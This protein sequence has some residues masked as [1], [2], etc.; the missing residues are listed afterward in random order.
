[1]VFVS[2]TPIR[3][4]FT[5]LETGSY[6]Y[7]GG[8][9]ASGT[10]TD[11][12]HFQGGSGQD[13]LDFSGLGSAITVTYTSQGSGTITDGTD[14][15]SFSSIENLILTD[16][17]DLVDASASW[18]GHNGDR[19]GEN[20]DGGAGQD[21]ITG[22][23]G[24]DTIHGGDGH[25]VIDGGYGDDSLSGGAGDDTILG[26]EG[27]DNILGG[28]GAD[29]ID[30]GLE[31][32]TIDGG[33]GGDNIDGGSGAD[34]I[35]GG[36]GNDTIFGSS[37]QDT[38]TGGDGD[39]NLDGDTDDDL[40]SGGAGNDRLR[41]G[42]G[43][44][45][46]DG[47]IGDDVLDGD[48]G[49]DSLIGGDGS[50]YFDVYYGEGNDTIVGGDGGS[51]VDTLDFKS[52][53]SGQ[54]I[55]VIS[56]SDGAGTYQ[57]T[58]AASVGEYSGIERLEGTS[59]DDTFD[60]SNDGSGLYINAAE[61]N[62][63]VTAGA[64]DDTINAGEGEDTVYGGDGDDVING[65]ADRDEI[66]GDAGNDTIYGDSGDDLLLGD[67]GDDYIEGGDGNDS[68]A[69]GEG[70]DTLWGGDGDDTLD[71]WFGDD[72]FVYTGDN[73]T[74]TNFNFDN[75]GTLDDG[76]STNNDYI[77]LSGFYDHISELY[78]DQADDGVL[79]QSNSTDTRGN[80]TDYSDNT[81]FNGGS[82][83]MQGASAD[84]SS[85]T[86]ENT[87][88][89]CFTIGTSIRTPRGDVLIEDLRIGDLVATADNGPQ[90]IRWIGNRTLDHETLTAAPNLRPILIH[91]AVLGNDRPLLVSPQHCM[92]LGSNKLVRAKHLAETMKD[93]QIAHGKRRVSYVHLMFDS[94]Q[95]IFAENAPSESFY[96]GPMSLQ[97]MGDC[98]RIELFELFPELRTGSNCR[99]HIVHEYGE[100]ARSILK[101]RE[102]PELLAL[103]IPDGCTP[104]LYPSQYL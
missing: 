52:N 54:G 88:I 90:A 71:G 76:D 94:H 66:Y 36:D 26:G 11:I 39:D 21:T 84:N 70:N 18:A 51:N 93:V 16:Q 67:D 44:D 15:I 22:G 82:L 34:L 37:G 83:R 98:S 47:G 33:H 57:T 25:D 43:N 73:D 89:V 9:G 27:N 91:R 19:V 86:E 74:I 3:L 101:K 79:N 46:L 96:P 59:E 24:G 95:V 5:T 58:D 97:M 1:M 64:G 40:V 92:L 78:A 72:V 62:D 55:D 104:R 65:G 69:G 29:S 48:S 77:D 42:S 68:I 23:R 28:D 4:T 99:E 8:G 14:T 32:D 13:T 38:I 81:Q 49:D 17:D 102:L 12:E 6:A 60:T 20:I 31:A 45:T 63:D 30:G 10:F 75:L 35:E 56:T 2:A 50:D 61:G 80:S 100:T 53:G 41:G 7:D 85:F 87:G 103:H